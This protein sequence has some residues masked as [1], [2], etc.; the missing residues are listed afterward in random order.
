M[1]SGGQEVYTP[2][3][4]PST[5]LGIVGAPR[6]PPLPDKV[7]FLP[8]RWLLQNCVEVTTPRHSGASM[9]GSKGRRQAVPLEVNQPR[10]PDCALRPPA[11]PCRSGVPG[12]LSL[13][14]GRVGPRAPA[15]SLS[16][17]RP[18]GSPFPC[19]AVQSGCHEVLQPGASVFTGTRLP[20]DLGVLALHT[21]PSTWG[22][23]CP[24]SRPRGQIR[25]SHLPTSLLFWVLRRCLRVKPCPGP[26]VNP[27][28]GL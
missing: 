17:S 13:L 25:L 28:P 8:T 10:C 9:V 14:G 26:G 22:L 18:V 5:G 23:C 4:P 19:C 2:P 3:L 11:G 16:W 6:L 1:K 27:A 20:E 15:A 7:P 12:S 21:F 24:V